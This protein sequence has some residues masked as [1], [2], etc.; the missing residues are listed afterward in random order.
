MDRILLIF[1][2][3]VIYNFHVEKFKYKFHYKNVDKKVQNFLLKNEV[4]CAYHIK[5]PRII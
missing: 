1:K 3:N 2:K 5:N 4:L